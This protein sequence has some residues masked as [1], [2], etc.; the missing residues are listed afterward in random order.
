MKL[1]Y[2]NLGP[3]WAVLWHKGKAELNL[4]SPEKTALVLNK[5]GKHK[6][7]KNNQTLRSCDQGPNFLKIY[8][9]GFH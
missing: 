5:V 6:K 2:C 9:L 8:S 3:P 7:G 4:S 1:P